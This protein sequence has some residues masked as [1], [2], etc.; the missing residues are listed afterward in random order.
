[1]NPI[2]AKYGKVPIVGDLMASRWAFEAAC[3]IQFRENSYFRHFAHA[4][5]ELS[6]ASYKILYW[7]PEMENLVSELSAAVEKNAQL[8][9]RQ[10]VMK[11]SSYNII[12]HEIEQENLLNRHRHMNIELLHHS[13]LNRNTIEYLEQ[14]LRDLEKDYQLV[15]HYYEGRREAISQKL[16]GVYGKEGLVE[17]KQKYHNKTL[18]ELVRSEGK[19]EDKIV[20]AGNSLI[21]QSDPVFHSV[22]NPGNWLDYRAHF[23]SPRK[24]FLGFWFDTFYFN[25]SVIWLMVFALFL[26]LYFDVGKNLISLN[27]KKKK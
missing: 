14:Y 24:H 22:P 27:F 11:S 7:I 5:Q 1:M 25:L 8:R 6:N 9:N 16:L 13:K 26:T 15:R 17:L 20:Q 2:V 23:F 12:I 19:W 21:Q 3:L 18:E 4:E 10:W